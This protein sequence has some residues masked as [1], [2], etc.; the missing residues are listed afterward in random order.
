MSIYDRTTFEPGEVGIIE[1]LSYETYR[2]APGIAGSDLE[3]LLDSPAKFKLGIRTEETEEMRFGTLFHSLVLTGKADFYVKPETYLSED[4]PKKW[5]GNAGACKKWVA[6]H[7]DK[8]IL[9]AFGSHSA[10]MLETMA[11]KVRA[12]PVA[13]QL[14]ARLRPEVSVFARHEEDG[15]LLKGR[16]DGLIRAERPGGPNIV[17]EVKTTRDSSTEAFSRE[18]WKRG[19]HKKA[20]WYQ[21]L[22]HQMRLSPVEH[23]YIA[24][25]NCDQARVNVRRLADRAMAKAEFDND[26]ALNLYRKCRRADHWPEF[27]DS[28]FPGDTAEVQVIDLPEFIYGDDDSEIKGLTEPEEEEVKA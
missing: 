11:M 9:P 10:A 25:E 4:G 20:Q 28:P 3:T 18:I 17:V 26:D 2:A 15:L 24:V 8:P 19:Y 23:W 27:I 22:L 21:Y 5:N 6:D 14:L 12:H 1:G 13:A 7:Q 16:L